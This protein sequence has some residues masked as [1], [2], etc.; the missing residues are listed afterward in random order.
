MVTDLL[1]LG[2]EMGVEFSSLDILDPSIGG[3][4]AKTDEKTSKR[5]SKNN[6]GI[7][8]TIETNNYQNLKKFNDTLL[9]NFKNIIIP[10]SYTVS[11]SKV[12]VK[13]TGS[14]TLELVYTEIFAGYLLLAPDAV[15]PVAIKK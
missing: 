13:G 4:I 5:I 15:M 12:G 1:Q 8:F 7:N 6:I 11:T 3:G 2:G 10:E 9:N 14:V